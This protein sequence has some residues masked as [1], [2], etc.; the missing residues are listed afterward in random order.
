MAKGEGARLLLSVCCQI[1]SL[2]AVV[3]RV[4][5]KHSSATHG[6]SVTPDL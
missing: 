2:L 6:Y 4:D 3:C 1:D 5:W